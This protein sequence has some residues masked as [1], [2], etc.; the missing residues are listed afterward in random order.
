LARKLKLGDHVT[1]FPMRE[2]ATIVGIG[3]GEGTGRLEYRCLSH[4]RLGRQADQGT[5]ECG[6]STAEAQLMPDESKAIELWPCGCQG[7]CNVKN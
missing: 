6:A 7:R 2:P 5:N 1:V 4:P 3:K